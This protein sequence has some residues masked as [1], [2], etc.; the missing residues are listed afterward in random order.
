MKNRI[1]EFRKAKRLTQQQLAEICGLA[2]YIVIQ[3]YEKDLRTPPVD[4]AMRLARALD[5]TVEELFCLD[6]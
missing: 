4:I 5:T 2:S 1:L 6:D 3:R